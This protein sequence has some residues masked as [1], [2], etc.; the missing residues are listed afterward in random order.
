MSSCLSIWLHARLSS[1]DTPAHS[2]G[3]FQILTSEQSRRH[4]SKLS[5]LILHLGTGLE[6]QPGEKGQRHQASAG[7]FLRKPWGLLSNTAVSALP[8]P[9]SHQCD[10][11]VQRGVNTSLT[12][13]SPAR[14]HSRRGWDGVLAE[15]TAPLSRPRSAVYQLCVLQLHSGPS[16]GALVFLPTRM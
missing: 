1:Q 16:Y 8:Q 9:P 11:Q 12:P 6:K 15:Q 10:S 14:C 7:A 4:L 3:S 2:M 13:L 5:Q